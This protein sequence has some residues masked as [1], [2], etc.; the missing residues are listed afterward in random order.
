MENVRS[1]LS[2]DTDNAAVACFSLPVLT[3]R[4]CTY[5][6]TREH[7]HSSVF[8]ILLRRFSQFDQLYIIYSYND[9]YIIAL[10]TAVELHRNK[11]I[12]EF[13]INS[14]RIVCARAFLF[15]YFNLL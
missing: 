5:G 8:I 13:S 7:T 3:L 1:F 2:I 10:K 9:R 14:R 6:S 11:I 15:V 4:F 12:R